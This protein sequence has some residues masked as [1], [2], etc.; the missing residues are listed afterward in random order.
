[1]TAADEMI[2]LYGCPY[3]CDSDNRVYS[4]EDTGASRDLKTQTSKRM[5]GYERR[6]FV[7]VSGSS[8]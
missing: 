1:M 6:P 3:D 8:W 4:M 2:L 5:R 7:Q